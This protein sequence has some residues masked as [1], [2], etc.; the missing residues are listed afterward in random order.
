MDDLGNCLQGMSFRLQSG[1]SFLCLFFGDNYLDKKRA[2]FVPVRE[3]DRSLLGSDR[4]LC[5]SEERSNLTICVPSLFQC[6][7]ILLNNE[8]NT[9]VLVIRSILLFS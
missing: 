4:R 1:S 3:I 6:L 5:L 2:S 7:D 9:T 8:H